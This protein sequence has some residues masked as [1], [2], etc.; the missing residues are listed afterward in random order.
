MAY[1]T[2]VMS[3]PQTW[4][5]SDTCSVTINDTT[6][7]NMFNCMMP[8]TWRSTHHMVNSSWWP[9]VTWSTYRNSTCHSHSEKSYRLSLV[10]FFV[11]LLVFVTEMNATCNVYQYIFNQYFAYQGII[12]PSPTENKATWR[13]VVVC[14]AH[15][16]S[17]K[18]SCLLTGLNE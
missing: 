10:L 9:P 12:S 13:N 2:F 6:D 17:C 1:R 18:P 11:S 3:W 14:S 15:G 7:R 5:G 16:T 8:P 4:K